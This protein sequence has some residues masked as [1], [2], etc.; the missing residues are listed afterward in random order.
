MR[1]ENCNKNCIVPILLVDLLSPAPFRKIRVHNHGVFQFPERILG[2][3]WFGILCQLILAFWGVSIPS[4]LG[5]IQLTTTFLRRGPGFELVKWKVWGPQ[6][7]R[8]GCQPLALLHGPGP[9]FP[10]LANAWAGTRASDVVGASQWCL[11]LS[12]SYGCSGLASIGLCSRSG[13]VKE[14]TKCALG[15]GQGLTLIP[16]SSLGGTEKSLWS[17]FR[18]TWLCRVQNMPPLR[19]SIGFPSHDPFPAVV[20][21]L[22][23]HGLLA[24]TSLLLEIREDFLDRWWCVVKTG[25][26]I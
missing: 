23:P 25:S 14:I 8:P 10:H 3:R 24:L 11:T 20:Q 21:A 2:K 16:L 1:H 12:H 15:C 9:W 17:G 5:S 4:A 7:Q 26:L 6:G 18:L 19:C 13:R 22:L